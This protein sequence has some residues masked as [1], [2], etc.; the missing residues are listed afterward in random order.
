MSRLR[1]L[2]LASAFLGCVLSASPAHAWY[3]PEHVALAKDGIEQLPSDVR[4]VLRA[5]VARARAE[6]LTSLCPRVDVG[7]DDVPSS[8]PMQT[9]MLRA[10][11]GA[12]CVPFAALPAL[13]GDHADGPAELRTVLASNKGRELTTAAA[14]EWRRFL[15][16]VGETPKAPVERMS[17]VHELDVDFYFLD[18]GY[19]LRAQRTRSHFVDASKSLEALV[20]EVGYAGATDNAIGQFLGH[21]LRS[22]ERATHD[23]VADALLEHGFAMHFLEDAFSAGHLVMT[24]RTWQSGNTYARRRHDFFN[25]SGLR[26]KRATNAETCDALG[27]SF[28]AGL[29]ACWT[30]TGDG[31]LGFARDSTDRAYVVRA[32]KKAQVQLA[33][34]LDPARVRAFFEHLGERERIAFGDLVDPSPWWT[35]PR[36][37]RR[38][39]PGTA[40]W[41]ARLV[42]ATAK[43][44]DELRQEGPRPTVDV[45]SPSRGP[46]LASTVVA[47]A[48]DPCVAEGSTDAIAEGAPNALDEDD[49]DFACGPGRVLALGTIGTSVLRPL[50]VELPSAQE[51]VSKLEGEA[52]NDHGLSFQLLASMSAGALFPSA[53][54]L[55]LFAPSVGGSL[56]LAYR[57]GTY[58][59]GRRN[60]AAFEVNAGIASALHY[61]TQRRAGGHPQVTM[62]EQEVRWPVL[63]ELLTSYGLP[64]DLRKSHDAGSV[65]LFGGA[66][67]KEALT[68][69]PKLWGADIEVAAYALSRGQGAYP[70]YSVSPEIRFHLGLADPGV[71]QPSLADRA[72]GPTISLS[73]VGGYATLF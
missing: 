4:D 41:A 17:F 34:A 10:H 45:G 23:R 64:L 70:L 20:R 68:D 6:G 19:E 40:A 26:V 5:G 66:R 1:R 33:I 9:K 44:I 12:D 63:W 38:S 43:A 8:E 50:L 71:V 61:D 58:L 39:R 18:P 65:I 16:K 7:L 53:A 59:P 31:Y 51:D 28:E 15:E 72:W 52:A 62:L 24:D 21:H 48:L 3:F 47:R 73:L 69:A 32:L 25:A 54:P 13:A 35:L 57:F 55:D 67:I 46:L 60:R 56:G 49:R 22:L 37:A 30:T 42:E 27:Q 14:Y 2:V 11:S 36:H 29:P